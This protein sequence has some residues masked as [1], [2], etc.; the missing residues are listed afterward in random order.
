MRQESSGS[1][2]STS[3]LAS[4]SRVI[5]KLALFG[6]LVGACSLETRTNIEDPVAFQLYGRFDS[7]RYVVTIVGQNDTVH[8]TDSLRG[9]LTVFNIHSAPKGSLAISK[10][11][12]P[13]YGYFHAASSLDG[14]GVRTADSVEFVMYFDDDTWMRFT[15]R[16]YGDSLVGSMS[17]RRQS[18]STNPLVYLGRFVARH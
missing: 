18:G 16:D 9:Q 15:A 13:C 1:I 5:L 17:S 11:T 12:R 3:G 14:P 4:S 2:T 6:F 8:V 7:A 10:C